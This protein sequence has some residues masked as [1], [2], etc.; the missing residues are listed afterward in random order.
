VNPA[1]NHADAVAGNPDN[2]FHEMLAGMNRIMKYD[3]VP[4]LHFPVWQEMPPETVASE[5]QFVH[6]QVI[7]G[8][9]GILHGLR[10][11]LERLHDKRHHENGNYHRSQQ[12]LQ[13]LRPAGMTI[14]M[15]ANQVQRDT[16]FA[17]GREAR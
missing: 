2:S 9:Q 11:N 12:R 13:R 3:N 5:M 4:T 10:G 6:Q 7:A 15:P 8:E 16:P 17:E 1:V 14:S